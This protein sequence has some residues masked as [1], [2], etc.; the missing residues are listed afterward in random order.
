MKKAEFL[1]KE[2]EEFINQNSSLTEAPR[3][4]EICRQWHTSFDTATKALRY[5]VA[6]GFLSKPPGT[7]RYQI[8]G[9]QKSLPI[10]K[11]RVE[12]IVNRLRHEIATGRYHASREFPTLASLRLEFGCSSKI[13]STV[14]SAL[15]GEGLIVKKGRGYSVASTKPRFYRSSHV[16]IVGR[17]HIVSGNQFQAQPMIYGIES[18]LLD[19]GIDRVSYLLSG[20]P[21]G[22]K[23]PPR[24][25]LSGIIHF[26][27]G[28]DAEQWR[29]FYLP[30]SRDPIGSH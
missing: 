20:N 25:R 6:S 23:M 18:E 27:E 16:Y 29:R 4:R 7:S 24:H 10:R 5:L 8:K 26:N 2:L 22:T 19:H 15:V 12:E 1:A 21:S 14:V 30:A 28:N 13:I 3:V 9:R 17:P 11:S